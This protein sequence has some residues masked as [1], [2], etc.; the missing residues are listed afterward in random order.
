ML[1]Q[2]TEYPYNAE[3]TI[4]LQLEKPES[5]AIYLRVPAWAGPGTHVAVNGR[6]IPANLKPGTFAPVRQT[7]RNGDRIEFTLDRPMRL[8]P[9]D[10]QHPNLVALQQGPLTLFAVGAIPADLTRKTLLA[11]AQTGS[12]EWKTPG[13]GDGLKMLAYP[14]IGNE[15]YRLYLP[16]MA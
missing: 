1:T 14:D 7:W 10:P 11:T 16:V 9:V 3:T 6:S 8:S 2:R 13:S 15:T 12:A 4:E 5:F